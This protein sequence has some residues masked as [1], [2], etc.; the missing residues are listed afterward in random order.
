M[1]GIPLSV[2]S[3]YTEYFLL[4]CVMAKCGLFLQQI[5]LISWQKLSPVTETRGTS[6]TPLFKICMQLQLNYSGYFICHN[7]FQVE[8]NINCLSKVLSILRRIRCFVLSAQAVR[9]I[10][11][12]AIT[13]HRLPL[14]SSGQSSWLNN[15]EVLCFL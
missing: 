6:E 15:G 2:T 13:K 12:F 10:L 7:M 11:T 1:L 5:K 3:R 4:V 14:W 8:Y 9:T